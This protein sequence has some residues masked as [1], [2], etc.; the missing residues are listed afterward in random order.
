[1]F[2]GSLQIEHVFVQRAGESLVT[3]VYEILKI[4]HDYQGLMV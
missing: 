4:D 2:L 3:E 1:M